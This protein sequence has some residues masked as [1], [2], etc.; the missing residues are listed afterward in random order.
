MFRPSMLSRLIRTPRVAPLALAAM[1]LFAPALAAQGEPKPD[2]VFAANPRTGAVSPVTGVVAENGLEKVVVQ[3]GEKSRDVE[4]E[5]VVRIVFGDVPPAYKDGATYAERGDHAEAA[6]SYLLA[7]GDAAARPIVQAA[8]RLRAA[9]EL[10]RAGA[11]DPSAYAR[12]AGEAATFLGD[13]PTNREVPA[14]RILQARAT[15]LSSDAAQ[16]AEM[17]RQVF[18]EAE[19]QE[20]TA[21]YSWAQCMRSGLRAAQAF[22]EAGDTASARSTYT[23]LEAALTRVLGTL[24]EDSGERQDLVA[25]QDQARLGEGWC[26]LAGGNPSQAKTFF[27]GQ[28]TNASSAALLHGAELGLAEAQ[29]AEGEVRA[30]QFLFARVSALDFVDRDRIARAVLGLARCALKL[31]DG[32]ARTDARRWLEAIVADYGDTPAAR[33]AREELE[34]L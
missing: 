21:G 2:Q 34:N 16:A 9:E 32:N 14:A 3:Q 27:R 28:I 29:L 30:A 15:A 12:A 17:Y 18:R 23:Q 7:A 8:S 22:V 5:L 31:S 11:A 6:E 24:L 25:I 4:S 33:A 20:P 1:G 19:N 26:L 13:H 10:M